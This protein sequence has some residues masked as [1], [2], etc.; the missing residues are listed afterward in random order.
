MAQTV[1]PNDNA[2]MCSS[3]DGVIYL[4]YVCV[5]VN[6]DYTIVS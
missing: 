1:G 2:C 6:K 4:L 3:N 5:G